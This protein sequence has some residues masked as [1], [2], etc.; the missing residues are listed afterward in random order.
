D[1]KTFELLSQG[2]TVGVFQFESPGMQD[3]LRKMKPDVFEDLIA[4]GALYRPGPMDNIP[5]YIACKHG[6]EQPDYL[7][8]RLESVLRETF[9]VI[10]YQEQVMEIAQI[11]AGYTLGS[12]DLLRRAMGKKIKSEMDAQRIMFIDGAVSRSVDKTQASNIFDLVSKFAGY[13]FNKS[14]AAAYALISYQTAY[15]KANYP[16]EFIIASLNLDIHDTDKISIFIAEAKKLHIK[17]LSPDIN[18][19]GSYFTIEY[20]DQIKSIRYG[21]GALKGV[22]IAAMDQIVIEKKE[23][24][25][26]NDISNFAKRINNKTLNKRQLDNLIK[27]G[28]FDSIHQN[29]KQ[30]IESIDIILKYSNNSNNIKNTSQINLFENTQKKEPIYLPNVNDFN[31]TEKLNYECDSI[32]F[33]LNDHPINDLSEVLNLFNVKDYD[34]IHNRM[35][36]GVS[37]VLIAAVTMSTKTKSSPRGRYV[38]AQMSDPTGTFNVGIYNDDV[39]LKSR[40]LLLSKESL[41]I[42]IEAKKDDGGIRLTAQSIVG[43][44]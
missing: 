28:T 20:V 18:K 32:G 42:N 31:K 5:K 27:S 3:A 40:D 16:V 19:S 33:Y 21:L 8:P 25:K 22:G 11:L 24:G 29:R 39:L 9:G 13:G 6:I 15:L 12:A 17:I 23:N 34:Y 14:H 26:F 37:N 44:K 2:L 41:L 4:L 36:S 10:I 38:L 43:L 1:Q 7:H 35:N 30:L